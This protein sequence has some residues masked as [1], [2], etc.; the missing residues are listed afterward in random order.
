MKNIKKIINSK[1]TKNIVIIILAILN[2]IFIIL[3]IVEI[4]SNKQNRVSVQEQYE[5][6]TKLSKETIYQEVFTEVTQGKEQYVIHSENAERVNTSGEMK[7]RVQVTGAEG[8]EVEGLEIIAKNGISTIKGRLKNNTGKESGNFIVF[9]TILDD[10]E[11][12]IIEIG[13]Y[14]NE[15]GINGTVEFTTSTSTDIANAYKYMVTKK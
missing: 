8:L 9:I 3:N 10:D 11:R 12:E 6:D 13:A 7:K 4:T 14:V 5:V 1:N 2:I 15:V